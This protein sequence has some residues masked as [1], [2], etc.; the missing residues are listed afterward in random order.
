MKEEN[1]TIKNTEDIEKLYD[2]AKV[3]NHEMGIIKIDISVIRNDVNWLKETQAKQL[4]IIDKIDTRG[5]W[6]LGSVV[7]GIFTTI[8]FMLFK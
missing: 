3:A 8:L 2:H 5:W 4:D 6:I 7:L 1:Q